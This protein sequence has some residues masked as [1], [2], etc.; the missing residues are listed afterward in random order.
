MWNHSSTAVVHNQTFQEWFIHSYVLNKVG[1]SPLVS[2]FFWDDY[3][4]TSASTGFTTSKGVGRFPDSR[5][6]VT[7]D[8]GLTPADFTQISTAYNKNMDA[9]R[10]ATLKAGKFSWQMLW[11]GGAPTNKG[12]TV[13]QPPVNRQDCAAQ[14]RALCNITS[15]AQTRAMMYQ[16]NHTHGDPSKL[17]SFEQDLA[18][19]LLVRG[20]YA[21]LGHG[22][23][24]CSKNYP[25]PPELNMDYGE[26]TNGICAETA[27]KSG[28]FTRS[29]THVDVEMDCN[30]W[31]P[32]I[33][34]KAPAS[35]PPPTP[36]A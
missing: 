35:V 4:P 13:P 32:S 17:L 15:P 12:G 31:L 8:I 28:V 18:N 2:G 5:P 22:W 19:F 9:L 26:P 36:A 21:W 25:F 34:W 33:K 20:P 1:M 14:L 23:T 24:G 16:L 3:W 11:T 30:T 27:P 7:E 6:N 29:W 10:E